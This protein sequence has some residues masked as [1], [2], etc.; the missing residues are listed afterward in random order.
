[1]MKVLKPTRAE[2][3]GTF[4][5]EVLKRVNP[6][7]ERMTQDGVRFWN[8]DIWSRKEVKEIPGP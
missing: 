8:Q 2:K 7:I 4:L 3:M 1:M 6:Q 5:R